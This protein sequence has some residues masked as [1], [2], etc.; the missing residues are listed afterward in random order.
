MIA[1]ALPIVVFWVVVVLGRKE[2]GW[3]GLIMA[4]AVWLPIFAG[5]LFAGEWGG[6]FFVFHIL[7]DIALLLFVYRRDFPLMGP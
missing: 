4:V 6:L 3:C 7:L 2:L 1:A 5:I